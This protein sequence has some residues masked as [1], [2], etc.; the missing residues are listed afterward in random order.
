MAGNGHQ[1]IPLAG[2]QVLN[3]LPGTSTNSSLLEVKVNGDSCNHST[4]PN[5][6]KL[7]AEVKPIPREP[8]V[9]SNVAI[10]NP[11]QMTSPNYGDTVGSNGATGP[12]T[13]SGEGNSFNLSGEADSRPSP[14]RDTRLG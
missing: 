4:T 6:T 9:Q 8:I 1:P 3:G 2:L 11:T 10:V 12:S 5:R 13:S 7:I 14:V